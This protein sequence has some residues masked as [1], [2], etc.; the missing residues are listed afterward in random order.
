MMNPIS[1]SGGNPLLV[2][3]GA[4]LAGTFY[5]ELVQ[6]LFDLRW[7][8]LFIIALVFT[9]FWSGLTASVKVRKEDFRLSRALRRTIVK[10]L[11]YINFIIFGLL[12]AKAILEPFGI[13]NDTT[14]GAVGAGCALLIE[15]DSI[16]GHVCDLHGIHN[17]FSFKRLFVEWLKKKDNDMGEALEETLEEQ[18]KTSRDSHHGEAQT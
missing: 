8:I 15:F 6:V 5:G 12:L 14:G 1:T 7:L 17:R 3:S 13:G 11:E 9:D 4:V 2:T 18:E 10:F 16:Y